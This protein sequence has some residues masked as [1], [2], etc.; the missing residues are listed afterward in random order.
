MTTLQRL[1]SM[2]AD[3]FEIGVEALVPAATLESLDIDSLRMIEIVF[4]IE[5]AFGITVSAEQPEIRARVR[6]LGDLAAFV[7]ELLAAQGTA[8]A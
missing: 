3:D 8:A 4:R 5:E 6:T 2:L 7:D 1:Q